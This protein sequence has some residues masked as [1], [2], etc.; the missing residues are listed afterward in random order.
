MLVSLFYILRPMKVYTF[1]IFT[2][3]IINSC[4]GKLGQDGMGANRDLTENEKQNISTEVEKTLKSYCDDMREKGMMAEF[5]YLDSSEDFF[6][7]PPGY[8][9]AI[10]YDSV[11]AV[12]TKNAANFSKVDN[13]YE[14]L[15]II[16][17]NHNLA[18]YTCK[19]KSQVTMPGGLVHDFIFL[20]TGNMIKR[21]QEWKILSG[22]TTLIQE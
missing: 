17:L 21:G 1:C 13:K 8:H 9:S 11:V 19:L 5:K 16:P 3:I 18:T 15:R 10:G 2:A 4:S 20:E 22:Q 14:T 12:V 6:W 7:V